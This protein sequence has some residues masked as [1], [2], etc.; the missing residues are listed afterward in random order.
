MARI[1][2]C[3][4]RREQDIEYVNRCKPDYVGFV[5]AS[6][7]RQVTVEQAGRLRSLLSP[8]MVPVGVFV[9][10]EMEVVARLLQEG[11]IEIAQLHGE[12]SEEYIRE[13]KAQTQNAP[14]IKAVRV[15]KREDVEC[16]RNTLADY[17][18]FD[19]FSQKE[20]GGTGETF[21]WS[22]L[23]GAQ[24][25][26][27]LAGGIRMEKVQEAVRVV[28][29]YGVDVSSAVETHGYK[30]EKKIWDMVNAVRAL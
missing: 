18:L 5:F 10:E 20:Y 11:I 2:I 15:A 19:A 21:D 29:P 26:F 17:L 14:I 4:L 1:K 30:D 9:N 6:S 7:K 28:Q 13:L 3:G 22:L 27:F 25:P 12:E 23:E 24:K 16:R 8:Q